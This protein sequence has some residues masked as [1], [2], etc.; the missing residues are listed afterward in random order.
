[1]I[2]L[3]AGRKRIKISTK[4]IQLVGILLISFE[5]HHYMMEDFIVE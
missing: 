3:L 5:F 1:M 4:V 2:V